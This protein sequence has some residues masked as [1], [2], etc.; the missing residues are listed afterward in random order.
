MKQR[1][2]SSTTDIPELMRQTDYICVSP[3]KAGEIACP[4]DLIL[5]YIIMSIIYFAL[6][7]RL[8]KVLSWWELKTGK[9]FGRNPQL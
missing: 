2:W 7:Y 5:P 1:V 6:T 9:D 4:F 8:S 3:Q